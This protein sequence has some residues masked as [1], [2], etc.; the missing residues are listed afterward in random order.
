MRVM[1]TGAG[2]FL[3]SRMVERLLLH[4]HDVTAQARG[5]GHSVHELVRLQC[6]DL[7]DRPRLRRELSCTLPEAIVHCA[8][9][10]STPDCIKDRQKCWDDN[11]H[12][13]ISVLEEAQLLGG[14][15]RIV[16]ASSNVVY[17]ASTPYRAAKLAMET[18]AAS[19]P[20]TMC[21][22]YGNLFGEGCKRGFVAAAVKAWREKKPFRLS[23]PTVSRHFVHVDDATEATAIALEAEWMTG[24]TDVAPDKA[25]FLGQIVEYLPGLEIA[26]SM[27]QAGDVRHLPQGHCCLKNNWTDV[28]E[29]LC[30][31]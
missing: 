3:G 28:R 30:G 2:G 24:W 7:N 18:I 4:G 12:S 13:A 8:G 31:L 11:L 5:L 23:D 15:R 9:L 14:V 22:R 6:F 19:Y 1:V 16:L 17:G 10:A 27:D 25:T 21:L 20:G 29:W 26:G